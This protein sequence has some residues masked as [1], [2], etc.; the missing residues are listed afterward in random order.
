MHDGCLKA[1]PHRVYG[2]FIYLLQITSVY[3]PV[4]IVHSMA[5]R[6]EWRERLHVIF[7]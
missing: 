4:P 6:L 1:H 2:T 3:P 5:H 7:L